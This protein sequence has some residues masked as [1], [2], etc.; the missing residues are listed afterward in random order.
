[1]RFKKWEELTPFE[2]GYAI[3][4][5]KV[6]GLSAGV[7]IGSQIFGIPVFDTIRKIIS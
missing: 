1:M 2:Q 5:S 6:M 7:W 4:M 3:G